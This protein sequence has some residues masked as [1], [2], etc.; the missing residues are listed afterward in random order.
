M[1]V[2]GSRKDWNGKDIKD[3]M[4]KSSLGNR[5]LWPIVYVLLKL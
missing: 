5:M 2:A 3:E 4:S 1:K